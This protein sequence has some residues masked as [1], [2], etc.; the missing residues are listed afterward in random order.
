MSVVKINYAWVK[1][2]T[3]AFM[4]NASFTINILGKTQKYEVCQAGTFLFKHGGDKV[5]MLVY[6]VFLC[7]SS[8]FGCILFNNEVKYS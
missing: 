3:I 8:Q 7:V 1:F 4:A 5:K 2:I 6:L